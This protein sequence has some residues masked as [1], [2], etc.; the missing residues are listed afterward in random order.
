MSNSPMGEVS[1]CGSAEML[2]PESKPP[3][4]RLL[5]SAKYCLKHHRAMSGKSPLG[6][7]SSV[8]MRSLSWNFSRFFRGGE[9][10]SIEFSSLLRTDQ[11]VQKQQQCHTLLLACNAPQRASR[12]SASTDRLSSVGLSSFL[13]VGNITIRVNGMTEPSTI[14]PTNHQNVAPASHA[15]IDARRPTAAKVACMMV[16]RR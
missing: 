4:K 16:P 2:S 3:S 1:S 14:P 7:R 10:V 6:G 9:S 15:A 12:R 5:S 11:Q 13:L 8:L